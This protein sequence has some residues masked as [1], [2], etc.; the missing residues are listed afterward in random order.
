MRLILPFATG[1]AA[2]ER[3]RGDGTSPSVRRS[4]PWPTLADPDTWG[5][6]RTVECSASCLDQVS[7]KHNSPLPFDGSGLS[8]GSA[9][10]ALC[11]RH[12]PRVPGAEAPRHALVA[13]FDAAAAALAA[14]LAQGSLSDVPAAALP[15]LTAAVHRSTDLGETCVTPLTGTV[16]ASGV[17]AVAG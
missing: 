4:R 5:F 16:R 12:R 3:P 13:R 6:A 15:E 9:S 1:A 2:V 11:V 8:I 7:S 17:L 10:I 14:E